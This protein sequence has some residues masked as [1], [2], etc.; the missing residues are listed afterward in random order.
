MAYSASR[1]RS[2]LTAAS[3]GPPGV[4]HQDLLSPLAACRGQPVMPGLAGPSVAVGGVDRLRLNA[5][6]ASDLPAKFQDDLRAVGRARGA[7]HRLT[8]NPFL[9]LEHGL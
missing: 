4:G 5:I 2:T 9:R 6:M 7:V 8:R 3:I 1:A